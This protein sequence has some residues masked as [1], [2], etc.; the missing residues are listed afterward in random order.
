MRQERFWDKRLNRRQLLAGAAWTAGGLTAAATVGCGEGE[1]KLTRETTADLAVL[2][3]E[4]PETFRPLT[5]KVGDLI[6]PARFEQFDIEHVK[7]LLT[8][9]AS[10]SGSVAG[11]YDTLVKNL[12]VIQRSDRG[13][14]TAVRICESGYYLTAA[15]LLFNGEGTDI[16]PL[17]TYTKIYHPLDGSLIT[18]RNFI[19]DPETDLAILYAPSGKRSKRIEGI[20]IAR[21]N[22]EIG[23][24]LWQLGMRLELRPEAIEASVGILFGRVAIPEKP[25]ENF[26][27]VYGMIPFGG[28]SGG[29]IVDAGGVIVAIESGFY[30]DFVGRESVLNKRENYTGSKISP[31]TNLDRLLEKSA[32][33]LPG[34]FGR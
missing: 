17:T 3:G 5:A 21:K 12:A 19:I 23:E 30:I 11:R 28:F 2:V 32:Y 18:A 10:P 20:Q 13:L 27:N 9:L 22:L 14:G 33:F 34:R 8:D 31:L 6:E 15:H 1:T 26:S 29:P 4:Q 7:K 16:K 24:R 25:V